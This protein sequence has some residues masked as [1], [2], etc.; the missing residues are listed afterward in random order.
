MN[1][2]KDGNLFP[3]RQPR[4]KSVRLTQQEAAILRLTNAYG[5]SPDAAAKIILRLRAQ[6]KATA[7][8]ESKDSTAN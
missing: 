7:L 4:H 2:T 3:V 1:D 5:I 8:K 6:K